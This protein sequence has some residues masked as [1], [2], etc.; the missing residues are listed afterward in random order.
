MYVLCLYTAHTKAVFVY[1]YPAYVERSLPTIVPSFCTTAAGVSP[2][3]TMKVG[4]F[5]VA[6]VV[7][8]MVMSILVS[9]LY[10]ALGD[11][12][13]VTSMKRVDSKEDKIS[14]TSMTSANVKKQFRFPIEDKNSQ[15]NRHKNSLHHPNILYLLADD[16]GY[17]DVEY[18]GGK[19]KTPNLNQMARGPNSVLLTRFYLGGPVCSPTR[20][21]LL[22]GRNHNRYCIWH[23]DLGNPCN[24]G[25]CPCS[26]PLPTSEVTLPELLKNEGYKTAIFGK[27][28]VGDLKVIEGGNKKWPV[29][30]PGM[31]GFDQW[32]VTLRY[33]SSVAPNC[34]CSKHFS[35]TVQKR[36]YGQ[37]ACKDYHYMDKKS[38]KLQAYH[39]SIIGDSDFILD[40]FEKYLQE[41]HS[42]EKPFFVILAFHDVHR[43]YYALD[44]YYT[45]YRKQGYSGDV[46]HYYGAISQ[47]DQAIGRVRGLLETYGIKN[48]TFVWFSSDNGPQKGTPGSTAG[49]RGEKGTVFEGGIRVPAILEWPAVI[50]ANQ[51]SNYPVVT[52]DLLPTVC[53]ILDID[54]PQDRPIDGVS[55]LPFLKRDVNHRN[56]SIAFAFHIKKGDLNSSFYGA[57]LRDSQKLVVKYNKGNI[58]SV[59]LYDVVAN[60]KET[61]D[62]SDQHTD[63]VPV[64]KQELKDFLQSVN[65]SATDIGCISIHDRRPS[66]VVDSKCN[67]HRKF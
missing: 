56:S 14:N 30:H 35:C 52:N 49:L 54:P 31:H 8:A 7:A 3:Q 1:M 27:W 18:N 58:Q 53:D 16:L 4:D 41:S 17:G 65:K 60:P 28:H 66:K 61:T 55:I 59:N 57:V 15:L 40:M 63:L 50:K 2:H 44:P 23:A 36:F 6:I 29:S 33:T 42:S 37:D 9:V 46:T 13:G 11:V 20:G 43:V 67:C 19:A 26:M 62:I 51:K 38:D 21:T 12:N 32:L 25:K 34:Q 5:R 47:L 48:N 22:T 24:D 39:D 10:S 45:M 64:L